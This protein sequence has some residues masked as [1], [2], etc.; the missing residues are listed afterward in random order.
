MSFDEPRAQG[1]KAEELLGHL[2]IVKPLEYRT[3]IATTFGETD[4][5]DC[6][7]DDIETGMSH[8]CLFFQGFLVG[9]FKGGIGKTFL[10]I[11][12]K[13]IAKPSQ[14]PPFQFESKTG[15][16]AAVARAERFQTLRAAGGFSAPQ[17]VTA[18]P[19][20]TPP[21]VNLDNL[22]PEQSAALLA[23]LQA[24]ASQPA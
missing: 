24:G 6:D 17:A 11:I 20:A 21:A 3:G 13:G 5:I 23:Q 10:G 19:A 18:P 12:V 2:L 14:S 15:D 16:P 22:S 1:P 9:S 8:A 7:V 4:A